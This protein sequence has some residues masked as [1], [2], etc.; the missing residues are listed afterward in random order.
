M[1]EFMMRPSDVRNYTGVGVRELRL[2]QL[3]VFVSHAQVEGHSRQEF[4][5]VL[6]EKVVVF[7]RKFRA[8]RTEA[9]EEL[10]GVAFASEA[11]W[12]R[13]STSGADR[14]R[15]QRRFPIDVINDEVIDVVVGVR[16]A[17]VA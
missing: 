13:W 9:L 8:Q 6:H 2:R 17:L 3:L 7:C 14:G 4:P 11:R 10:T 5:I 12:I 15:G 16:A 1:V